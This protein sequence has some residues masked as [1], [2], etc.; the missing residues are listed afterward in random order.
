MSIEQ[1]LYFDMDDATYHADPVPGGSLSSTFARLLTSHVPAKAH[2][3]FIGR[4]PT[5]SMNL[6]KAAHRHALG[7]GPDLVTWQYDGRTK[8]GKA[9]RAALA[10]KLA[11]EEAVAVTQAERSQIE[12]MVEALL[13]DAEVRDILTASKAEVSGFWTE[14]GVWMRARYDLLADNMAFDY[15]TAQDV[16]REGFSKALGNYAYHQQADHYL[17]G[18]RALNHTAGKKPFR[19]ICQEVEP[20]YLVQIH[21]PDEAAMA[22]AAELNNRAI[23]TYKECKRTGVWP[24]YPSLYAEPASLPPYYVYSDDELEI[25]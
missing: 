15:K 24:G 14:A 17:R 11:T 19:F 8:E 9:E 16:S 21:E 25:R 13:S 2:A 12:G 18:L 20:P 3:R 10:D 1:R 4:K 23:A 5:K 7:C 6:G 22:W